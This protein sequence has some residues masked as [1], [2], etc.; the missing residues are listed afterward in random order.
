MKHEYERRLFLVGFSE[1][2]QNEALPDS[3]QPVLIGLVNAMVDILH[4][5]VKA[6]E[7]EA[8]L[9]AK[10]EMGNDDTDSQEEEEYDSKEDMSD[11]LDDIEVDDEDHD[12]DKAVKSKSR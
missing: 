12:N 8:K 2:L 6:E 7:R 1:L 9:K 3:I 11:D 5:L 4:N 10:A